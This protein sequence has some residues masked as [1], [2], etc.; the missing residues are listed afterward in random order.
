MQALYHATKTL[1]PSRPVIG[2]DGWESVATDII[3]IHDYDDQPAR[4]KARYGLNEIE[5][6]LLKRER[7]GGRILTLEGAGAAYQQPLMIT[8][9]G[10]IA[11][12][13]AGTEAPEQGAPGWG[14]S[15]AATSEQFLERYRTLLGAVCSMPALAG[16]CYTQFTDTY[17]EI[18][19]LLYADRTPKAPLDQIALATSGTLR[20]VDLAPDYDPRVDQAWREG[21]LTRRQ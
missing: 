20:H 9:F 21:L 12:D 6:K 2:N 3:G 5:S 18:N 8:E 10:G 13:G 1:D 4:M 14:Y 17:Q 19:G 16:F 7:P 15:R 11:F